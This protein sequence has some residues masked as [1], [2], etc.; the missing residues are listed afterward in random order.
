M[1]RTCFKLGLQLYR[2]FFLGDPIVP[3]I[4][5]L[6]FQLYRTFF[7]RISIVPHIFD[8]A[9]V[10]D[11]ICFFVCSFR[12]WGDPVWGWS[13]VHGMFISHPVVPHIFLRRS[14]CTAHFSLEIQ[15][16]RSSDKA[17]GCWLACASELS[18]HNAARQKPPAGASA[19]S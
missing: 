18:A 16:N 15:L 1:Y 17:I 14:N 10:T 3:H 19:R 13:G 11:K 8:P 2:T 5:S 6:G 12:R 7:I 4:F 9:G